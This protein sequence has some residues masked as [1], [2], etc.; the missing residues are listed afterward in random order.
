MKD[1]IS[2]LTTVGSRLCGYLCSET[3]FNINHRALVATEFQVLGK[4]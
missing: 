3:I 4:G 2:G 1:S